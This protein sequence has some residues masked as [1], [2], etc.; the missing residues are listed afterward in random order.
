MKQ[1]ALGTHNFHDTFKKF[2][3]GMLRRQ[4][5]EFPHPEEGL[6]GQNRRYGLMHQLLPYVE[7]DVLWDRWDQLDFSANRLEPGGTVEWVGEHFFK[8][9]V[10]TMVCPSNPGT[11]WNEAVD[12][13]DSGRYFRNH[14]YGAAGTRGYP[15]RNDS[16]PSLYNPFYPNI[17][18][19]TPSTSYTALADGIF[20]QNK[21]Y[22]MRDALDGTS[23]TLLLG[24]RRFED[25][26]FDSLPD[27]RI[28]D[29]GWAWFGAQGDCFLGTGVPVNFQLPENF[30]SLD[31]GTQQLLYDDRINAYG[32]MHPGGAQVALV[33]GSVRFISET[34][35]PITFRALGTRAGGEVLG[36]F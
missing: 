22:A 32:S 17:A 14:Y 12:P 36:E 35:S 11:L 19:P 3:Y 29:W 5:P 30:A 15:R 33:D 26:V 1:L 24:E 13:A 18:N 6:A 2:P 7:Q 8:Q 21:Q 4:P 27:E 34:I 9:V 10:M 16:R 31:S 28:R 25:R 20:T 23:N